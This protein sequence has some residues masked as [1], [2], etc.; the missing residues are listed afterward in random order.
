MAL[1]LASLVREASMTTLRV[2]NLIT[3][4]FTLALALTSGAEDILVTDA[5]SGRRMRAA[6]DRALVRLQ[7]RSDVNSLRVHGLVKHT[8]LLPD[9]RLAVVRLTPNHSIEK[10]LSQLRLMPGVVAAEPDWV[11]RPAVR[12]NDPLWH[13]QCGLRRIQLSEAWELQRGRPDVV[14][15]IIDSGVAYDHPDLIA[16]LA[17]RTSDPPNGVDDDNN[18]LV[19]DFRG[20]D[21]A[22]N[23]NDPHADRGD[24][25]GLAHGT[26]IAGLAAAVTNNRLG[27]AGAAWAC[28]YLPVR[29]INAF[30]VG[31]LSDV[32]RGIEYAVNQGCAVVNLSLEGPFSRAIQPAIDYAYD[33]NVVVCAAAGND[34]QEFNLDPATW[35]SP[36]CNDGD[37]PALTNHVIGVAAIGCDN[38][39]VVSSNY[40]ATYRFV[41][42]AAPGRNI[43]STWWPNGEY[44]VASGTSQ[45]AAL[46]SGA[47]ALLIA[48]FGRIS[49]DVVAQLLMATAGDISGD[50]PAFVGKLGAGRA[51][52]HLALLNKTP[53]PIVGITAQALAEDGRSIKR[54]RPGEGVQVSVTLKNLGV[55]PVHNVQATLRSGHPEVTVKRAAAYYGVVEPGAIASS[56]RPFG[57]RIRNTVSE[58]TKIALNI[59]IYG[60]VGGPWLEERLFLP[61]GWDA[62]GEPD[63]TCADAFPGEIGTWY[64]REIGT[65]MDVDFVR[66]YAMAGKQYLLETKP[67]AGSSPVTAVSVWGPDCETHILA[68]AAGEGPAALTWTCSR[69]GRYTAM[70]TGGDAM[71][72]GPYRFRVR[73]IGSGSAGP[74]EVS[75]VTVDDKRGNADG[76]ADP[77]ETVDLWVEVTNRGSL[78][79]TGVSG[80]LATARK[81]MQVLTTVASF[82]DVAAGKNAWAKSPY[83]VCIGAKMMQPTVP[84]IQFS[85]ASNEGV[86]DSEWRIPVG[87]SPAGEPDNSCMEGNIVYADD[88]HHRRALDS[89][90]DQDWFTFEARGGVKYRFSTFLAGDPSVQTRLALHGPFC[91]AP[92]AFGR[93]LAGTLSQI[94][95][96]CPESGRYSLVVRPQSGTALGP[97]EFSVRPLT[98][99]GPGE[100]DDTCAQAAVIV[101]NAVP[102][103]RDFGVPGDLDWFSFEAV[104]GTTYVIETGPAAGQQPR[105][106][107]S[108][109]DGKPRAPDTVLDLFDGVC[110]GLIASDDDS[111]PGLFSR[112]AFSAVGDGRLGIRVAEY[113]GALGAYTLL[114]R[115]NRAPTL[116]FAGDQG[117]ETDVVQ[118]Q[119][120]LANNTRFRF[121]VVYSDPD[122]DTAEYVRVRLFLANTEAAVSPVKLRAASGE[123]RTGVLYVGACTLLA[124]NY[125]CVVE[126]SDG[127]AQA[128]GPAASESPGPVVRGTGDGPSE[129][130]LVSSLVVLP[131]ASG[132]EIHF[133]ATASARVT[134]RILNVAGREVKRLTRDRL[135]SPRPQTLF[136]DGLTAAGVTAP[137]GTYLAEVVVRSGSGAVHSRIAAFRH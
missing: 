21:F 127:F 20:W 38:I 35:V 132:V 36:V 6:A 8:D 54:A 18:G 56:A 80:Q 70:I 60:D 125:R 9:G 39:K 93:P 134:A 28:T 90:D 59:S 86:W 104:D 112:L 27:I 91:A 129:A 29:V 4:A 46:V 118:P 82:P 115:T 81:A 123:P 114:V 95:W 116:R 52:V 105:E 121:R 25:I 92:I 32:A 65:P 1:C 34:A 63:D 83:T 122:G 47:A 100:P 106:T 50:N 110:G 119:S 66:F 124:G 58:G 33:H 23:D 10:A 73:I 78:P 16:N 108:P 53:G 44:T 96:L 77:G 24:G 135:V 120:G 69:T 62:L 26:H 102:C 42:L 40:G 41:D 133:T 75:R 97:Y 99:V 14:I 37:N 19:D 71:W 5:T 79:A 94:E 128:L 130:A 89:A 126:A 17:R 101:P 57:L 84:T 31:Y 131:R 137:H 48:Q 67:R 72:T 22:D 43:T 11:V 88:Y 117:Y 13:A 98:N 51:N 7:N 45:A 113:D 111:G 68:S 64:D 74:L 109:P 61:V 107:K 15:A 3:V 55:V 2:A 76:R 12:P 49:P 87:R 85:L 103:E 136:W 30:G